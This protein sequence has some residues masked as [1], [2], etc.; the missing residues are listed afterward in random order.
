MTALPVAAVAHEHL[1]AI[2]LA[3]L[4]DAAEVAGVSELHPELLP[5]VD[6]ILGLDFLASDNLKPLLALFVAVNS[7]ALKL[8]FT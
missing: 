3:F 8:S 7:E 4:A 6:L 1:V 5:L 2:L